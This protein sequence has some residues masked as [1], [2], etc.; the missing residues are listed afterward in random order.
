EDWARDYERD[1]VVD[2]PG[3]RFVPKANIGALR[4]GIPSHVSTS[5]GACDLYIDVRLAPGA[6][7]LAIRADLRGVLAKCGVEGKVELYTFRKA[8]VANDMIA[9]LA[10]A[11]G[12]THATLGYEQ[13]QL[14]DAIYSSMWRDHIAFIEAGIPAL[15][16]GPGAATAA[17]SKLGL[18]LDDL[19]RAAR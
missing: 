14:A 11:V 3:G 5:S 15:T 16:Y 4:A 10:E 9:P 1:G 17:G 7:P 6:D 8:Q 18:L 12:E 13:P 2:T 19:D